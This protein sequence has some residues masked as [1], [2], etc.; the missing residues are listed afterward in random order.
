MTQAT[1]HQ[2]LHT[3]S[4]QGVTDIKSTEDWGQKG[5]SD[6][7]GYGVTHLHGE[8]MGQYHHKNVILPRN[9][10]LYPSEHSVVRESQ[11]NYNFPN[12]N[13]IDEVNHTLLWRRI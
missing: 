11:N 13:T 3:P 10:I 12:D 9:F 2:Q 1:S 4:R 6:P 8:S 7:V 5:N